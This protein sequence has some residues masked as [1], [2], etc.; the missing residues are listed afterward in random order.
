MVSMPHWPIPYGTKDVRLGRKR[1]LEL[2]SRVGNPHL[3][4]PNVIHVA[5][6]NGKGSTIAYLKAIFQDAGYDVNTYTSPHI[7]RF[8]ERVVLKGHEITDEELYKICEE[9]RLAAAELQTTFFEATTVIALLAMSR[10]KSDK[11]MINLVEVGLG[12]RLDATNVFED[13]LCSIITM[14]DYD[15]VEYLGTTLTEIAAEK[16]AILRANSHGVISWQYDEAE[17]SIKDVA[18]QNKVPIFDNGAAWNFT[19]NQDDTWSYEDNHVTFHLPQPGLKGKHQ[20]M[21]AATAIAALQTLPNLNVGEENIKKGILNVKWPARMEKVETG[22]LY[23]LLPQNWELWVDGAHNVGGAKM[24]ALHLST[25]KPMRN[26]LINGRTVG[27]DIRGFLECFQGVVD[28][29]YAV[30]VYSEP[31]C[32]KTSEI[33]KFAH[34][35]NFNCKEVDSVRLALENIVKTSD[36]PCRLLVCG[37]LYLAAD[38]LQANVI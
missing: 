5:G 35:L 7:Y 30:P 10:V 1:V 22:L 21:N 19:I 34:D 38:M 18:N 29:I 17:R 32:E 36:S 28:E 33:A 15:H 11:E 27:R 25:L 14:I 20:Y 3:V 37:S 2:L 24:A 26:I 8:N 6:T 12:G 23:E 13:P 9:V 16:A 31:K 4:M